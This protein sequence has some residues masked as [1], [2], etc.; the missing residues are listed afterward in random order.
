MGDLSQSTAR[1]VASTLPGFYRT[2]VLASS[3]AHFHSLFVRALHSQP[4]GR[5]MLCSYD[6]RTYPPRLVQ[7]GNGAGDI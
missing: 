1:S 2:R 3:L 6:A 5:T 4:Y 7:S